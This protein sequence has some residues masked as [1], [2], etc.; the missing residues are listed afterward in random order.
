VEPNIDVNTLCLR[1]YRQFKIDKT[2]A[3]A[4]GLFLMQN[5]TSKKLQDHE[6]PYQILLN[7]TKKKK[8]QN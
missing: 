1:C 5:G 3:S 4:Y 2:D 8:N 7:S 6:L